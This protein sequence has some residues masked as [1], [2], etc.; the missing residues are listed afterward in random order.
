M[1]VTKTLGLY[2]LEE[3]EAYG[4]THAFGIPGVHNIELYRGLPH[5]R[6]R[7]VGARHEQALGFMA[8]GYARAGGRPAVCFTISGPGV[9]NI[10]TAAAQ[11]Y[12]DSIPM[13]IIASQNRR[14]EAGSGRG[15]LH[16]M[17]NQCQFAAQVSGFAHSVAGMHEVPEV[18]AR[19]F[20]GMQSRRPRP[21]YIEIPRDLLAADAGMLPP[22]TAAVMQSAGAAPD[23]L[24][25]ETVRRLQSCVRPVILAGGG[26]VRAAQSVARLAERLQAPVIMT[27]N[28]RGILPPAHPLNMSFS[29]SLEAVRA[30]VA[31]SDLTLAIG[32]EM[33]PTDYDMYALSEFPQPPQL[34]RI[35]IDAE[36]MVRN[37]RP[38]LALLGDARRTV[39]AL[40]ARLGAAPARASD[41]APA[42][43]TTQARTAAAA[44]LT[45]AMRAQLRFLDQLRDTL[46]GHLIVGDSTQ[47][48]YAGNLGF[49][50][51][52]PATW[53][54][55]ASGFGTLGYALPAANGAALA[56]PQSPVI[57]L[58][59]DGGLQ[60]T[61]QEL[62]TLRDLNAWV[63]VMVW[64]NNGF[65]EI[66]TS[67]IGAGVQPT[68]V[69][70]VPPD[71][72]QLAAA[73]GLAHCRVRDA[74]TLS[75]A[76]QQFA[77]RR[78]PVVVEIDAEAFG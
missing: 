45:P 78:G 46:P 25:A 36:Q 69:D 68:A 26:A 41:A 51:A 20:A 60:F 35:D 64:N 24:I 3:L 5:S 9:T 56:Q 67:M 77:R 32:T 53:F 39:E 59:G 15:F 76:L 16:E 31:G 4:I 57:A 19:A 14:G 34:L 58:V 1:S 10:A 55:S 54:N 13:L 43:C 66:K 7:H 44:A 37:A 8:D 23:E 63:A 42:A 70:L 30:L 75:A 22:P 6:I 47:P 38:E 72:A 11:A 52:A 74:A 61:L 40:L 48:V 73:Y 65:G 33:G 71:L 21:A 12:A 28:G 2:L 18:L 50:A 17:P 27:I 49:E 62:A 29:P